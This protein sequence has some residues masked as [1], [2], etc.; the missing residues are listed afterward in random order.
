MATVRT[1][2]WTY[3]D[4][5]WTT[6]SLIGYSVEALDGGIGKIDEASYDVGAG[7]LV[8]DTGPW[9][10]GKKVML[11]A[12]VVEPCEPRRRDRLRQPY[13]GADQERSR[14]RRGPVSRR[15]LSQRPRVVLRPGR[16]GLERRLGR[17]TKRCGGLSIE[18]ATAAFPFGSR[19]RGQGA[20]ARVSFRGRGGCREAARVSAALSAPL[21]CTAR[22]APQ[23][24][25]RDDRVACLV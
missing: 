9:I 2:I 1:E 12:G 21:L 8:V 7:Y 15:Q 14:V 20:Q 18:A 3:R 5:N 11:P 4:Q 23:P 13:E 24:G 22:A 19:R 17:C 10:F 6:G 25:G 16:R